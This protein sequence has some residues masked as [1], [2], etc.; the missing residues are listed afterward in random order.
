MLEVKSSS[1]KSTGQCGPTHDNNTCLD[2]TFFHLPLG[3]I[4]LRDQQIYNLRNNIFTIILYSFHLEQSDS[5]KQ[6]NIWLFSAATILLT[7]LVLNI[8]LLHVVFLTYSYED[9]LFWFITYYFLMMKSYFP[10]LSVWFA[11]HLP[12]VWAQMSLHWWGF[13]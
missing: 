9:S 4:W 11:S 8:S 13:P 3:V 12:Q 1:G 5:T 10:C 7:L 2:I 6:R